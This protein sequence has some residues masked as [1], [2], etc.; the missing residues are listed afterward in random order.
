MKYSDAGNL[1]GSEVRWW[2]LTRTLLSCSLKN[3]N[4]FFFFL[5]AASESE[6]DTMTESEKEED[7]EWDS[8]ESSEKTSE[9]ESEEEVIPKKV[10]KP[11]Y[12]GFVGATWQ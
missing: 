1:T 2:D 8:E 9:S 7:S 6:A 11:P 5:F 10:R 12:Y 3:S 4:V